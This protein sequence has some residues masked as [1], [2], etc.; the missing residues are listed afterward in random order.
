MDDIDDIKSI[1]LSLKEQALK[2]TKKADANFYEEYLSDDAIAIT[3]IGVFE[4]KP[5]YNKWAQLIPRS[6]VRA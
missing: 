1:L 2:A 4:K 5:L 6:K 3:P